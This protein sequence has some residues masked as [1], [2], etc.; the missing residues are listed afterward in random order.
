VTLMKSVELAALSAP[1]V[2]FAIQI[3]DVDPSEGIDLFAFGKYV[4]TAMRVEKANSKA[5]SGVPVAYGSQRTRVCSST[6]LLAASSGMS[7][8]IAPLPLPPV[9]IVGPIGE[10]PPADRDRLPA[11]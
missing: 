4:S 9:A 3:D 6:S 10:R 8:P 2:G 1:P 11:L 7:L 5:Q